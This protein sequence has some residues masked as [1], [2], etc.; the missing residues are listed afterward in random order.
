MSNKECE[1]CDCNDITCLIV[2]QF[3]C[4]CKCHIKEVYKDE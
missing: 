1:N 4:S 2:L 3:D